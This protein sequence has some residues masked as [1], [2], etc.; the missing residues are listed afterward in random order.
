MVDFSFAEKN[1]VP[2]TYNGSGVVVG[3]KDLPEQKKRDDGNIKSSVAA[4][5]S[6]NRVLEPKKE[7]NNNSI[8]AKKG[9][10]KVSE[11]EVKLYKNKVNDL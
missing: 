4:Y 7:M 11:E 1:V 9:E 6:D 2:K 10:K 3:K 8:V 5:R